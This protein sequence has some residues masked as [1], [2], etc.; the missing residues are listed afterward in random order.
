LF[1]IPH[2]F[3]FKNLHLVSSKI[4][5]AYGRPSSKAVWATTALGDVFVYDPMLTE[6]NLYFLLKYLNSQN[7][8][9]IN[10]FC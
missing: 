7:C 2:V 10:Y 5:N 3:L 6:V 8:K 1:S 9:K 4:N